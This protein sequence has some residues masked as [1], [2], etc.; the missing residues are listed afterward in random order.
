ML[1]EFQK[2][3]MRGNVLDLAVGVIIGSAFTGLVKSLTKNLINPILSMFAGKTDLSGLSFTLLGAKFTYGDFLNDVIN[4]LII[5]FVVFL[6]VRSV[7]RFLPA[8]PAKP[9]GPTQTE[10]LEEIRDLLKDQDAKAKN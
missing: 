3:I 4:F 10:L 5:A 2:F 8:K 6:I 9:A 1:K 7:N